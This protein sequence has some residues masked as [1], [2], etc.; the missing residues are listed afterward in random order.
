[1]L[2]KCKWELLDILLDLVAFTLYSLMSFFSPVVA[3]VLNVL[4]AILM[5]GGF[6]FLLGHW[7][8]V[9]FPLWIGCMYMGLSFLCFTLNGMYGALME[10]LDPEPAFKARLRKQRETGKISA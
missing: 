1:M 5:F 4:A 3:I 8:T 2:K 10:L 7:I 6:L 9:D